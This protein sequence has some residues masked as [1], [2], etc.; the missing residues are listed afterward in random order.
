MIFSKPQIKRKE[1][2]ENQTA[3]SPS[4]AL[5]NAKKCRFLCLLE[6]LSLFSFLKANPLLSYTTLTLFQLSFS[7]YVKTGR[8]SD[9]VGV[10]GFFLVSVPK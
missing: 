3:P 1:K 10:P 8:M 9:E 6:P 7:F 2:A 5:R 4:I